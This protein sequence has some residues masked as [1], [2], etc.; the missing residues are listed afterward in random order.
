M[1]KGFVGIRGDSLP[2]EEHVGAARE[3]LATARERMLSGKV[4][5][6]I[7][8]EVNVA[9]HLGLLDAG[10]VVSFIREK[11]ETVHLILSGRHAREEVIR[12]AHMVSEVRNVK[13]PYDQGIEAEKGI[14]Y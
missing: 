7:L 6:L 9:V 3:A 10:E 12:E 1:G 4:D 2:F 8:D 11:P 14:D 13:H 5:V